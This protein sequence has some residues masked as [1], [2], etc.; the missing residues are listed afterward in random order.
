MSELLIRPSLN[1]HKVVGALLTPRGPVRR[2]RPVV[3]RLVLDAP[4]A[5]A[6]PALASMA[7]DSGTPVLVDPLT[8]LLQSDVDP[9]DSWVKRV[10]FAAAGPVDAS[11]WLQPSRLTGLVESCVNFQLSHGATGII[12]PY[13][14]VTD[15]PAWLEASRRAIAETRKYLT[16]AGLQHPLVPV[17]CLARPRATAGSTWQA[18]LK[19]LGQA[20]HDADAASVALAVSG[21]GS[22]KDGHDAVHCL[23]TS[24][25]QL[26]AFDLEVIAWRQGGLGLACV[27]VGA[28]GYECGIG[29]REHCDI[30][31]LQRTRRP[32]SGQKP[33]GGGASAGVYV[34][35]M[36]RSLP[37]PIAKILS[38]DVQL[39]PR[40]LCT[41]TDCCPEGLTSTLIDPR[42]HDVLA[43]SRSLA[44]LDGM[45]SGQWQLN[46]IA[47]DAERGAMFADLA[48]RTLRDAGRKETVSAV[49][50]NALAGVADYLRQED[51]R[52]A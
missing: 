31:A 8:Y 7:R 20:A 16:R 48:T 19:A 27:A 34:D 13:P 12:A 43:R 28:V 45:P 11:T 2:I 50:L 36:G 29:M 1:D 22:A 49:S 26:R 3:N 25:R 24:I 21:T 37:R 30:K 9:T 17:L 23:L 38:Q 14:L 46:A 40:L 32:K 35:V 6:Q 51:D 18:R 10:P 44:T 4:V 47:R 33:A 42:R 15:D 39:R 5:V 41:D 52:V